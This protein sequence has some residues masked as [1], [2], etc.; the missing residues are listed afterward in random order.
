M[1]N[2]RNPISFKSNFHTRQDKELKHGTKFQV[3]FVSHPQ[4]ERYKN[5]TSLS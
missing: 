2:S 5:C 3:K 1:K 4:Y